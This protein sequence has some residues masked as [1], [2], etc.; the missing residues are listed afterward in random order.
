MQ[1]EEGVRT[2]PGWHSGQR[3]KDHSPK[4]GASRMG[5]GRLIW[6]RNGSEFPEAAGSPGSLLGS[7]AWRSERRN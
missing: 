1:S 5:A 2:Q 4:T 6:L 3:G 7:Q